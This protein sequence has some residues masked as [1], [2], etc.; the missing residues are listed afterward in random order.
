MLHSRRR[1]D[2]GC[3]QG[4]LLRQR[5]QRQAAGRVS[6][7]QRQRQSRRL[8]KTSS[9]STCGRVPLARMPN[10]IMLLHG[11]S[12]IPRRQ[13]GHDCWKCR[14]AG[15]RAVQVQ[16]QVRL[17][18]LHQAL[19]TLPARPRRRVWT[20][21]LFL[22]RSNC[23]CRHV[24][25]VTKTAQCCASWTARY[26]A[27]SCPILRLASARDGPSCN[28]TV[29]RMLKQAG[30]G[31]DYVEGYERQRQ[32]RC[33]KCGGAGH[34]AADCTVL[35]LCR[36]SR[37]SGLR[38]CIRPAWRHLSMQLRTCTCVHAGERSP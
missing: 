10:R 36:Q 1:P 11:R 31:A 22:T 27:C 7:R 2:M 28:S 12:C 5:A 8:G 24:L 20:T 14:G 29:R 13:P 4:V 16:E 35:T 33:F 15:R 23:R 34:W 32:T 21:N 17:Q 26:A 18:W 25:V 30:E 19:Q 3:G 38:L 9:A 37:L 6:A